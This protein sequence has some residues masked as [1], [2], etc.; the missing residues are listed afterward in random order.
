MWLETKFTVRGKTQRHH[1]DSITER[2]KDL[3]DSSSD[4]HVLCVIYAQ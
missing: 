2:P 3:K 1:F 4:A